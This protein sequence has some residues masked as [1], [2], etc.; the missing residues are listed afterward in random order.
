MDF[1]CFPSKVLGLPVFCFLIG[2]GALVHTPNEGLSWKEFDL[3]GFCGVFG[4][5]D[6][7]FV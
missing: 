1:F 5:C 4:I 3:P 7:R 6:G 2:R